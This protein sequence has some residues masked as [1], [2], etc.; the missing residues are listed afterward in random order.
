MCTLIAEWEFIYSA[1]PQVIGL[2]TLFTCTV[3]LVYGQLVISELH[4]FPGEYI[5]GRDFNC[6]LEPVKYRSTGMGENERFHV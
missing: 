6:V 5:E 4:T 2:K 1:S 3:S